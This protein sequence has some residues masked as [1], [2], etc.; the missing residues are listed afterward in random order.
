MKPTSMSFAGSSK[1][2]SVERAI[3]KPGTKDRQR[4]LNELI[5]PS[6]DESSSDEEPKNKD[7]EEFYK[8]LAEERKPFGTAGQP[9]EVLGSDKQISIRNLGFDIDK[10]LLEEQ[11]YSHSARNGPLIGDDDHVQILSIVQSNEKNNEAIPE[12]MLQQANQLLSIDNSFYNIKNT[13]VA[14]EDYPI[15]SQKL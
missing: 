15:I 13:L 7:K 4:V 11:T 2:P 9:P 6:S 10:A 3:E 5:E 12:K 14:Y 1:A 8:L